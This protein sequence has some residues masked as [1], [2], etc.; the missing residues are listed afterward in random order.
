MTHPRQLVTLALGFLTAA[1]LVGFGPSR[2]GGQRDDKAKAEEWKAVPREH[3][4]VCNTEQKN[5]PLKKEEWTK[6]DEERYRNILGIALKVGPSNVFLVYGDTFGN[7]VEATHKAFSPYG[8]HT[9]G[10]DTI[11]PNLAGTEKKPEVWVV[12]FIGVSSPDRW[13]IK[14]VERA[15][16]RIRVSY[17]DHGSVQGT[18]AP[19]IV[20]AKLGP[21]DPGRYTLELFGTN[22]DEIKLTRLVRIEK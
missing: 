10:A 17:A 20:W 5:E 1:V 12:A 3:I 8:G 9:G 21:L 22:D 7:A 14:K 16:T 19:V 4:R 11:L 6:F 2:A 18:T 13:T 15:G